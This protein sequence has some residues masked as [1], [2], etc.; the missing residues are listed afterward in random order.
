MTEHVYEQLVG[1]GTSG[2]IVI[3]TQGGSEGFS[4]VSRFWMPNCLTYEQ[5]L[6]KLEDERK[7]RRDIESNWADWEFTSQG[8]SLRL[9]NADGEVFVPTEHALMQALDYC[10]VTQ[11]HVKDTLS[12]R[13]DADDGDMEQLV[14][15]LN[16]RKLRHSKTKKDED[17]KL[18]FRTY[19]D[20]TLR[21][22]LT[23]LY[24][25]IDNRWFLYVMSNL[26]PNGMVS[27]QRGDADTLYA[28]ILLPDNVRAEEDSDYGGMFSIRNSEI[29]IASLDTKPSLFRA[30]CR[31]GCIW[32]EE[33]GV[34]YRQVHKGK[35]VLP[36]LAK[37]IS[38]NLDGQIKLLPS[39]MENFLSLREFKFEKTLSMTNL[40]AQISKDTKMTK[41][42]AEGMMNEWNEKEGQNRSAFGLVNAITRMSQT[43]DAATG[44]RFDIYA[45]SLI[46]ANWD[47]IVAKAKTL[48]KEDV[49]KALY[50]KAV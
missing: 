14:D 50:L 29:G 47:Q 39:I 33:K 21:A 20:N 31:N 43:M 11:T 32:D 42:Q 2:D 36:D 34:S 28:N 48:S 23:T 35:I 15:L 24:A 3:K 18:I 22:V 9:K 4:R 7:N 19:A 45:G 13:F 12:D 41:E 37:E 1:T 6:T 49:V 40:M 16:Y 44:N 27:H 46:G 26:I 17:R 5:C 10:S 30:I 8:N 38:D 25:T